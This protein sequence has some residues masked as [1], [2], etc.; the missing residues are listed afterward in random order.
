MQW[1]S[2]KEKPEPEEPVLIYNTSFDCV[3][4]LGFWTD[5]DGVWNDWYSSEPI[6]IVDSECVWSYIT[7]PSKNATDPIDSQIIL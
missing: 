7:S 3:E 1:R 2:C 5:E 6:T 4:T